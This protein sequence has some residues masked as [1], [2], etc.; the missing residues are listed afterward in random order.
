ML[1]EDEKEPPVLAVKRISRTSIELSLLQGVLFSDFLHNF[2]L[3]VNPLW[4]IDKSKYMEPQL[5]E[6]AELLNIGLPNS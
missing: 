1:C 5:I 6:L 4:F 3:G 2:A